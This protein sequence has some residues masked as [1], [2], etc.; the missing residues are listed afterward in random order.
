MDIAKILSDQQITPKSSIP[1]YL[2]IANTIQ[3]KI[4]AQLLPEGTRLPPERELAALYGVSRTTAINAYRQ[5]EQ[6]GMVK[7]KMGSGTYVAAAINPSPT[8]VPWSQLFVPP[9]QTTMVSLIRELISVEITG[10]TVSFAAGMPDPRLYPTDLFQELFLRYQRKLNNFELGHIPTEGSTSLRRDVVSLMNQQGVQTGQNNTMIVSGSQQGLYLIAKVFLSPGDYVVVQSPTYLGAIQIFQAAGARILTLP[11]AGA[12]PLNLLED[13]L[14]RYRPKLL[15]MLPTFQNPTGQVVPLEERKSLLQLAAKHRLAIVEDDPYSELY[16][17][18]QPPPSLKALDDYGCVI[19]LGTFS[20]V[21]FPGLRTGWM[22]APEKVIDRVAL[23][24]QYVDLHSSNLS[25]WLLHHFLQEG[26]LA[27][28]LRHIRQEYKKRRDSAVHALRRFSNGQIS[29]REPE[30]GFYLWCSLPEGVT[31]R[32]LL[33]ETAKTGVTFV[34]GEAFY[35][36]AGGTHEFRFCFA[37]HSRDLST[38]GIKRLAKCLAGLEKNK[39]ANSRDNLSR[40]PII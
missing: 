20:K 15:Y 18:S 23:E 37:T 28:H 19:Y 6:S 22:I 5:L 24:K 14:I 11:I 8:G 31:S 27:N 39:P 9:P 12:F 13:Y 4:M 29:F 2:Q 1:M 7:T 26:L 36:D 35:A 3:N 40:R 16:Y 38:D 25:Q 33:H 17:G 34:P 10:N 21:L 32:S 30:G